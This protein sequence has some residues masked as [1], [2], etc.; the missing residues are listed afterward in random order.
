MEQKRQ[1]SKSTTLI[2][3]AM[4][5]IMGVTTLI[6]KLNIVGSILLVVIGITGIV[7]AILGKFED[8]EQS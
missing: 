1:L 3:G 8:E 4:F 6:M 7:G 2:L 5:L